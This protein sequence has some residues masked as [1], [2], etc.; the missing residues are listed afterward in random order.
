VGTC[1]KPS[2]CKDTEA[3]AEIQ[4][5]SGYFGSHQ[6]Y[7]RVED[8][9]GNTILNGEPEGRYS[10]NQTYACL[11]KDDA[12]YTFLIGGDYQWDPIE[13]PPPT[14]SVYFD[15][16]LVRRSDSWL[17]DSVQFGGSC[18]PLC[19]EDDES[20]IEFFMYDGESRYSEVE[21]EY[22]WDLNVTNRNSS[23]TV[24][25]GVVPQGPDISPLAHKI[26]C[27]PKGSC[28]SFYISAP[29][30][31]REVVR[32]EPSANTTDW[33]NSTWVNVTTN[34]TLLLS[35]VYTLA[36][37]NVTY[38]KVQWVA[39]ERYAFG[40]T[41]VYGSN[42]QSTNMGRCTVGGLCDEQTQDL[43][44]LELRTLPNLQSSQVMDW[45]FGYTESED[46]DKQYLLE[47]LGNNNHAY[48]LDSSYGVI[49]CVPKDGCELSFNI[50]P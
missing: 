16:E 14:Y 1:T 21:Y 15:V 8:K 26:M 48:D 32:H 27:V 23:A 44:A 37:D 25:S 3:L 2:I 42:K 31:T 45:N 50:T 11:P 28:S 19:N 35:P 34:E 43:F 4:Y 47:A 29:N 10:V 17:F 18:K 6:H 46:N 7:F 39:P 22:E 20:L 33:T 12:C 9:E 38:R 41:L 13:I 49:E 30:V 40:G 5:W 36:M 24:S